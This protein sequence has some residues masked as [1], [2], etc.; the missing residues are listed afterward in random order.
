MLSYAV[1]VVRG[2][3]AWCWWF[4]PAA[5]QPNHSRMYELNWAHCCVDCPPIQYMIY[6]TILVAAV[7]VGRY[8]NWY[9]FDD[10]FITSGWVAATLAAV[11]STA[12]GVLEMWNGNPFLMCLSVVWIDYG[13]WK[14]VK[15]QLTKHGLVNK[16]WYTFGCCCWSTVVF[17]RVFFI[18][19]N[20][21][22]MS[23]WYYFGITCWIHISLQNVCSTGVT[24]VSIIRLA[25][26]HL[27]AISRDAIVHGIVFA[28]AKSSRQK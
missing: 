20:I 2:W 10:V 4:N 18:W 6:F 12:H 22:G 15:N 27:Y 17:Q 25:Y 23:V 3:W 16:K 19:T 5:I 8:R 24:S 28:G 9:I 1:V 13:N 21:I 26:A 7:A 14:V 11:A